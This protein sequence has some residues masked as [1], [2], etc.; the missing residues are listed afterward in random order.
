MIKKLRF[1]LP[2]VIT[3]SL[4]SCNSN[5]PHLDLTSNNNPQ[6]E[7]FNL[8]EYECYS[9]SVLTTYTRNGEL[10]ALLPREAYGRKGKFGKLHKYDDFSGSKDEGETHPIQTA[11]H[12]FLEEGN[13]PNVLGWNQAQTEDYIK[14]ENGNTWMIV[15]YSK[16]KDDCN[17]HSKAIRNVTYIVHFDKHIDIFLKNF[18]PER[19]KE[20]ARYDRERV[21]NHKR[22]T[23]EKDLL[24]AVR[25]TDL[26]T[27]IVNQKDFNEIARVEALVLNPK[28]NRFKKEIIELRPFFPMKLHSFF[29][30]DPYTQGELP[31]IRHYQG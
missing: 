14:P 27:A 26:A 28:T 22:I 20:V 9:G 24:S 13:L 18:Y 5:G 1:F 31:I 17:P 16:D 19:K 15:A 25:W 3:L 23:V 7:V 30:G 11:A 8:A 2:L 4:T 10:W 6:A 12:E 29:V 21:P